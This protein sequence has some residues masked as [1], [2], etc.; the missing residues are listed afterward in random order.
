MLKAF[1]RGLRREATSVLV[2]GSLGMLLLARVLRSPLTGYGDNGAEY[3]E[4]ST[5]LAWLL[6][7]RDR[8]GEEEGVGLVELLRQ[9]ESGFPQGLYFLGNAL[10]PVAGLDA[11]RVGPTVGALSLLLL[12]TS[13]AAVAWRL[14]ARAQVARA[15]ALGTLLLPAVHGSGLRY[16]FD[17][18]MTAL[19]WASVGVLAFA[20]ERRPRAAGVLAG[21][22]AVA[23]SLIKWTA[24]PFLLPM[25]VGLALC[26]DGKNG[27]AGL[28]R[29]SRSQLVP[30]A[31]ALVVWALG[32]VVYLG[33]VGTPNSLLAMFRESSVGDASY[34][35][36]LFQRVAF[37]GIGGVF[38]LFSPLLALATLGLGLRWLRSGRRGWPLVLLTVAGHLGF[39]MLLVRPADERFILT[40]A[41]ALV[42]AA[43]L[44]WDS[45]E[46]R[47]RTLVA[48]GLA[49]LGLL[50][51]L[52]FHHLP[53]GFLTAERT[54]L[55]HDPEA[56]GERP[57]LGPMTLRGLG[58][59]S[60]IE[61][62]G[63]SRSDEAA[64]ARIELRAALAD[65]LRSCR[66][67]GVASES[68]VPLISPRGDHAWLEYSDLLARARGQ[69]RS[70]LAVHALDCSGEAEL[71]PETVLLAQ[72]GEGLPGLPE[73][74][75]K[76]DWHPL[77]DIVDPEGG[78]AIRAWAPREDYR[79]PGD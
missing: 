67:R 72:D 77:E 10:R 11:E 48:G 78:P 19:V 75:A 31:L 15:A 41:P 51:A 69:V 74:L 20:G 32:V 42:L 5:R 63:W 46:G 43:A 79:C 28:R 38:A 2:L 26:G 4:H 36:L 62:R 1:L 30:F 64:P 17:L 58:A 71:P 61:Q 37:Y 60:S 70:S 49:G 50:I 23:A 35:R 65:W 9:L 55:L 29:P 6:H 59:A 18:P 24:V 47:G 34:E 21:L 7:I 52:D 16:Y 76:S 56:T 40:L 12:A 39:L 3:N 53:P 25:L 27:G 22:L 8:W 14:S 33:A 57:S 54:V 45:L 68:G 13:V 73:C 66:P 44:G